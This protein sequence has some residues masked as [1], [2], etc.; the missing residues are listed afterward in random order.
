MRTL[1]RLVLDDAIEMA[2]RS[3]R[4][5]EEQKAGLVQRLLLIRERFCD[6]GACCDTC[7]ARCTCEVLV[8]QAFSGGEPEGRIGP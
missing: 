5:A 1:S 8:R 6:Q 4:L 2:L 3:E 7:E